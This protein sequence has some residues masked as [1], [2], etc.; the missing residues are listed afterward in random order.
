VRDLKLK[1][2]IKKPI[3]EVFA[4]T[5]DPKNTPKWIDSIATEETNEWP[6]KLG[7]IYRNKA[8]SGDW[9]EYQVTDFEEN[10][11]FV[12]S[13]KDNSYHVRYVFTPVG[14]DSTELEYYEWVDKGEL[15]DVFTQEILNKLKAVMEGSNA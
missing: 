4:F 2:V 9:T 8:E 10:K 13:R 11:R 3:S 15:S 14:N 1:V 12:F 7:T 6:V 5:T